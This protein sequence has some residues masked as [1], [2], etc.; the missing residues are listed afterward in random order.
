MPIKRWRIGVDVGGTFTD[1]AVLDTVTGALSV[2]KVPTTPHDPSVGVRNGL[3]YVA[4]QVPGFDP[5]EL[6]HFLHGTT[7]T[8]NALIERTFAPCALLVTEGH[9]GAVQVQDQL[10]QGNLFDVTAG[11]PDAIVDDRHVFEVPGRVDAIGNVVAP[12]DIEA[13]AEIAKR[14]DVLG[15]TSVAVCLL[16]SFTN[17]LH[18]TEVRRILLEAN[19]S[20]RIT[21][22]SDVLPRIREW[23]RISTMLLNAC[24]E[25]LLVDYVKT[26]GNALQSQGVDFWRLFLMESNGGLMPFSAV[27]GGGRAVHTLLSGPAANVQGAVTMI[28]TV[29]QKS[30]ITVD[31][32]GTSADIAFVSED[33]A[34]EITEGR[35]VG[36]EI[37][38]PMLDVVTI[39]AGG[40]TISRVT[41]DGRLHVG[42][43][44][45]G[46]DPGPACYGR[47]G[48]L[49]TTTDADLV[50]GLLDPDYYLGGR[51]KIDPDLAARAIEAHVA[52]PL[53]ISVWE[54]ASA[55]L[56]VNDVHMADTIRVFAAQKG[57]DLATATLV[58][59]GGAGPLH[60]VGVATEIDIR[61]IAVPPQP[62]TFSAVGLL[63]TDVVQDFVQTEITRLVADSDATIAK[64]FVDLEQRATD[65]LVDQG[66]DRQL[67]GCQREVDARYSGQGFEL[68]LAV[69]PPSDSRAS[70]LL[71]EQFHEVHRRTYGHEARGETVEIVSYRVRAVVTLSRYRPTPMERTA[72][73]SDGGPPP[74]TRRVYIRGEWLEAP[75]VRRAGLAP[76]EHRMGPLLVEQPDATI[77]VPPSWSAE[78]DPFGNLALT[79]EA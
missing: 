15:V 75:V 46:A 43:E 4:E 32:G 48:E 35:L 14:L 71:T 61:R 77:F 5:A 20:L 60:A 23:P 13:V 37:Y 56:Q 16:F 52:A 8:T 21:L 38:V 78:H 18:E 12:L 68:R 27:V 17:P 54:A 10:R 41:P 44:S 31:I 70:A 7:I 26:L 57:I 30:L 45:A 53:G 76:G 63:C 59:S 24:L 74:S 2:H 47:G 39:G 50:L 19:P 29:D 9:R 65:A 28:G 34:L 25:P 62:A 69:P 66:F 49:P 73:A 55:M 3:R 22:S 42:P 40:G 11:H 67:V 6:E 51:M 1:L 58:P 33:G 79:Q 36:H 72:D 64:Q